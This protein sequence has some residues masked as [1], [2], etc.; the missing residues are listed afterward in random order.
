MFRILRC[1]VFGLMGLLLLA[2]AGIWLWRQ[3]DEPLSAESQ[4]WLEPD[5]R[6]VADTDNA[7]LAML[8]FESTAQQPLQRAAQVQA[9]LDE[10]NRLSRP[11]KQYE[12]DAVLTDLQLR[13][14]SG[15]FPKLCK[16]DA[17]SCLNDLQQH[18]AELLSCVIG[19]RRVLRAIR[20]CWPCRN[21][22]IAPHSAWPL[23]C[24]MHR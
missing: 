23:C 5:R 11:V 16:R 1:I 15:E 9:R 8:A 6:A 14:A 10:L 4:I 3:F 7:Y 22:S 19:A 18:R 13:K 12:Y 2:L 24:S 20:Q 17:P 21:S